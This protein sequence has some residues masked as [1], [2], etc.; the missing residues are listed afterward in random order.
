MLKLDVKP[1]YFESANCI[2]NSVMTAAGYFRRDYRPMFADSWSF[3]FDKNCEDNIIGNRISAPDDTMLNNLSVYCGV[4][5]RENEFDSVEAVLDN[6]ESELK[7]NRPVIIFI[8][9]YWTPWDS[10]YKAKHFYYHSCLAVGIDYSAKALICADSYY[11]H[12]LKDPVRYFNIPLEG[13]YNGSKKSS[14]TFCLSN[15]YDN[16][17]WKKSLSNTAGRLKNVSESE[18]IPR[19]IRR[20]AD[21]IEENLCIEKEVEGYE[22][23]LIWQAPIIHNI[24]RVKASRKFFV[25]YLSYIYQHYNVSELLPIIEDVR[26]AALKWSRV[27]ELLAKSAFSPEHNINKRKISDNIREIADIEET[28]MLKIGSIASSYKNKEE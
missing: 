23:N 6:I 22:D 24:L 15:A 20:F 5:I 1:V 19:A 14:A 11:N 8:D 10:I 27:L 25:E 9:G 7:G 3:K 12:E 4:G 2:E 13:F 26:S 21:E 17:D 18:S 16:I 28:A